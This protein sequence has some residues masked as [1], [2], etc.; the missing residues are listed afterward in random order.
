MKIV[1]WNIRGAG[2]PD[3]LSQVPKL[4]RKF[5]PSILFLFETRVDASRS[6]DIFPKLQALTLLIRL[7]W[8]FNVVS[9]NIILKNN[10]M[11]HCMVYFSH[12]NTNCFITFL[13]GYY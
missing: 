11:I 10:R 9:L 8:N 5:S 7:C 13:Y 4:S 3:F 1:V 2:H 12:L 6:L